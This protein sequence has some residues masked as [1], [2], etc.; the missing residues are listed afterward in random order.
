MCLHVHMHEHPAAGLTVWPDDRKSGR[1]CAHPAARTYSRT[2]NL[3]VIVL[4]SRKGGSGKTTLSSHLAVEAERAGA[5]R[6]A[7]ADTDPQGGLAA[8]YN[9][10]ASETPIFVDVS[11]GLP[12]AIGACRNGGIDILFVDTP[13]SVTETIGAVVGHADLV[14]I[15][16]RPSPNDLRAVGGTVEIVR[17]AGKPM[18]FVCNQITPAGAHHGGGGHCS[19]PAWHRGTVDDR[20]PRRLRDF[21]DGRPHGRRA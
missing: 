9:A 12:A 18:V 16:V 17:R 7:L 10:R 13:P 3:Q 6:V 19:Q 8:W 20:Q 14:V 21:N 5:G 11:R 15:P 2:A 1:S 4:A